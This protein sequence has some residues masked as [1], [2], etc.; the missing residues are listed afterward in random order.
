[1][2]MMPPLSGLVSSLHY[3][4][5]CCSLLRRVTILC[6]TGYHTRDLTTK[7]DRL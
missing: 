5:F 3:T 4:H 6:S 1:M 7:L 2:I